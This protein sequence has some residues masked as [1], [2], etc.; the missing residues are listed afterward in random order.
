MKSK[1]YLFILSISLLIVGLTLLLLPTLSDRVVRIEHQQIIKSYEI[2]IQSIADSFNT[3][4]ADAQRYNDI[5]R[6]AGGYGYI[7]STEELELYNSALNAR[8]DGMMG[9]ISIPELEISLPIFHGSDESVLQ[10]GIGHI[11]STALPIGGPSNHTALTG[12]SGLSTAKMFSEIDKLENEDIFI[13]N[14]SGQA[15]YYQ[16]YNISKVLPDETELLSIQDGK[17]LCTL[18]TCTP[19]GVNTHR[20]LVQGERIEKEI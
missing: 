20:L 3:L 19:Y 17:D 18:I 13:L 16:I 2:E 14:I 1:K 8:N 4:S 6:A 5:L 7:P 9:Y 10:S 12:H 11:E 15:L